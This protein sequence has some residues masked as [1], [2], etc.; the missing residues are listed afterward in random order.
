MNTRVASH[1]DALVHVDEVRAV[2]AV[3]ARVRRALVHVRLA[4]DSCSV[5]AGFS[6]ANN[7]IVSEWF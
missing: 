5:D 6:K 7:W 3:D 2:G 4:V 1:A